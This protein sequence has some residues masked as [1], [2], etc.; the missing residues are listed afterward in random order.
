MKFE[1]FSHSS[2]KVRAISSGISRVIANQRTVSNARKSSTDL[3]SMKRASLV[4]AGGTCL[5]RKRRTIFDGRQFQNREALLH[6]LFDDALGLQQRQ[7]APCERER[8]R[9][10]LELTARRGA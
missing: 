3:S 7:A 6:H 8:R 9:D 5:S 4:P 1:H 2:W 10:R